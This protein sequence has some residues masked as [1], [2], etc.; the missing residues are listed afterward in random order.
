MSKKTKGEMKNMNNK[1]DDE[2]KRLKEHIKKLE[3]SQA[4]SKKAEE[5]IYK[6]NRL[7]AVLSQVNQAVVRIKDKQKL[8]QEICNIIIEYGKFRLAWIGFV[9]EET[10]LVKPIAFSGEGSDYLKNIKISITD[11]L[12]SKGPTGRAILEKRSIIFNDL[13]NNSDYKPWREQALEK[14]YRSSAA[15]PIRLFNNMIGALNIYATEPD[16][17]DKDNIHLLEETTLDISF[18]LEKYNEKDKQRRVE[19]A[20]SKNEKKYRTLVESL[21]EGIAKVDE[22]EY[23]TFVNQA[24]C[25]IFGYS[26][27]ELLQMNFK[28]CIAPE[29]HQKLLIQTSKRKT[30]K[31]SE[32]E[33]NIIRKKGDIRTIFTN[34]NPIIENQ[35][36]KGAFGIFHDITERKKAEEELKKHQEHLEELVKE[37]TK[38]LEEANK[39]LKRYNKLFVGREFRIKELKDRVKELEKELRRGK[40]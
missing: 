26:K 34:V 4:E 12:I 40:Y 8:L 6:A 29:D 18:A 19:K 20:L 36:Y 23:F 16:F 27:K 22:Y 37:R 30:G 9:D 31:S 33:L 13:E 3:K 35:E 17:F 7:Y 28:E 10:K 11:E 14:G 5:K 15:F 32:Y 21:E 38:E 24:T 25:N 1:K 2:I 39:E